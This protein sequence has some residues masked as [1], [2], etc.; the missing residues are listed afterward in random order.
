MQKNNKFYISNIQKHFA[1][2]CFIAIAGISINSTNVYGDE[3]VVTVHNAFF[4]QGID[5]GHMV[6]KVFLTRVF[7][8]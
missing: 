3:Q 2:L 5:A 4:D 1:L 7:V 6:S 8:L